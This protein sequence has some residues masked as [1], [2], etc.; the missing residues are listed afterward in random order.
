ML[1]KII[2][3]MPVIKQIVSKYDNLVA[4]CT[5][6]YR[7]DDLLLKRC[8]DLETR[9]SII[10]N[11]LILEE[12]NC[13]TKNNVINKYGRLAVYTVIIGDYD[14]LIEPDIKEIENCDYFCFTDN[15]NLKSKFWK[16]I[17]TDTL[18]NAEIYNLDNIR[19]ARYVKTHPHLLLKEYKHSI[20]IDANV[21]FKKSII[22]WINVYLKNSNI[23]TSAHPLRDCIYDEGEECIIVKKDDATVIKKQLDK[24]KEL[25]YPSNNGL[26]MSNVM[27]R[28]NCDEINKL[29]DEWW[30]EI[31]NNSRRDQLSFNYV[32][33]KNRIKYDISPLNAI[34]NSY[35]MCNSHLK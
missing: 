1:K 11:R 24:Y 4:W 33:Y 10:N 6:L 3:K 14:N 35:F 18:N 12:Y 8:H 26:I 9:L 30:N 5:D 31:K 16:V 25:G 23:L 13:Q 29:N 20:F 34:N 7:K 21:L 17:S 19:I 15:K 22:E 32:C 2:R 27:Y 28:I